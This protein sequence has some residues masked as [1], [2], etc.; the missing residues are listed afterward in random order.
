MGRCLPGQQKAMSRTWF[1][2]DL[3]LGHTAIIEHCW[4]PF[5]SVEAMNR[6]LIDNWNACV[7]VDDVVFVLGDVALGK[8]RETIQMCRELN[9]EKHLWPGNHDTCWHR[10]KRWRREV[11]EYEAVGF[12]VH[13]TDYELITLPEFGHDVLVSHFPYTGDHTDEDRFL[14]AR[15]PDNGGILLHGHCH[16]A[17][18][19]NGRQL[20]VGV[21]VWG[22]AP[23]EAI[24]L[25]AVA[26]PERFA[27]AIT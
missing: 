16:N 2:A 24:V 8:T 13:S 14:E 22:F 27:G 11:R 9:G 21:D 26:H 23:V 5:A 7:G 12:E 18:R 4:R 25:A 15:P 19:V 3:H 17:W 6:A 1:T 10:H 20:N